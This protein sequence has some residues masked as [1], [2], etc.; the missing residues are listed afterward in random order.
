MVSEA[1]CDKPKGD[2]T[3]AL[4]DLFSELVNREAA[5]LA[6]SPSLELFPARTERAE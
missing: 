4:P 2:I 6:G 5:E 3:L 1:G